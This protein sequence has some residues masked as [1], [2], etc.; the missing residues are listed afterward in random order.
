MGYLRTDEKPTAPTTE[1]DFAPLPPEVQKKLDTLYDGNAAAA[2]MGHVFHEN[3]TKLGDRTGLTLE[4]QAAEYRDFRVMSGAADLQE[5]AA[6][7]EL[8]H[9]EW[10]DA[11]LAQARPGGDDAELEARVAAD[12]EAS[13]VWLREEYGAKDGEALL[14]RVHKF[15]HQH[16]KLLAILETRGIGSKPKVVEALVEHVRR[17]NFR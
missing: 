1:G 5:T 2:T 12:V 14:A 3:L 10:T 6:L 4:E 16:P 9:T 8:L 17:I 15:A 7:A 11:R 13:R